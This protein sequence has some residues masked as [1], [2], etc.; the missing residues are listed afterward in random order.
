MAAVSKD[1]KFGEG[2]EELTWHGGTH[3]FGRRIDKLVELN[4]ILR[5]KIFLLHLLY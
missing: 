3:E 2:K 5:M 1:P 4:C